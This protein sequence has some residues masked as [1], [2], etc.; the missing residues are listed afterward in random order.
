[1]VIHPCAKYD[2]PMLIQTKVM[3]P[4]T[5]TCQKPYKFDLKYGKPMSNPTKVHGGIK[6]LE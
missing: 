4:D 3:G 5:K 1:M 6:I 2:K